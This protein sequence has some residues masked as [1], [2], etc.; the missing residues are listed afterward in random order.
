MRCGT[1]VVGPEDVL[2]QW[3]EP[4]GSK[5]VTPGSVMAGRAHGTIWSPP[6]CADSDWACHPDIPL[7]PLGRADLLQ[8]RTP[9]DSVPCARPAM[10]DP[11][12]SPF[13]PPGLTREPSTSSG[14]TTRVPHL[15]KNSSS[16]AP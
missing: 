1:R 4:G 15:T 7:Q 11:G 9:E 13:D 6:S 3:V 8:A 5:G 12:V 10:T 16:A 14:S 2:G